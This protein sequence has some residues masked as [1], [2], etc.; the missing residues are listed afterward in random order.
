MLS[1]TGLPSLVVMGTKDAD[2]PDPVD[3]AKWVAE[4][5]GAEVVLMQGAGHYPQTEMPEQC[6]PAIVTFLRERLS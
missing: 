4:K 2:F 3:E 5:T 1:N 6:G